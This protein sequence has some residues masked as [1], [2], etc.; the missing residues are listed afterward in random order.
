M[1]ILCI[2]SSEIPGC[3][4]SRVGRVW[5]RLDPLRHTQCFARMETVLWRLHGDGLSVHRLSSRGFVDS[6]V[7]QHLLESWLRDA[8]LIVIR[9]FWSVSPL[10]INLSFV[11]VLFPTY[12]LFSRC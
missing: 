8:N 9:G 4:G 2:S 3:L 12:C 5:T 11:P 6:S 10:I 1:A 7:S